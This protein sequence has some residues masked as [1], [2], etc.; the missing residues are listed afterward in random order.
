MDFAQIRVNLFIVKLEDN[1]IYVGN[2]G[3]FGWFL[4]TKVM[5]VLKTII[6]CFK[7]K[8]PIKAFDDICSA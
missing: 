7:I 3:G 8:I 2:L 6:I 1:I 4:I 5:S